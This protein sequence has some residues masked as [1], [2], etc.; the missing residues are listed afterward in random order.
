MKKLLLTTLLFA[1]PINAADKIISSTGNLILKS[2]ASGTVQV[3]GELRADK[4][5]VTSGS[6]PGSVPIGGMVAVMPTMQATDTWQP[7]AT[8]AIKDGFMRADGHTIT[9]QNVTDGSLLR[10][11]T[12]LPNMVQKYPRGNTTSG[13]T[14]G[15]NT[16]ASSVTFASQSINTTGGSASFNKNVMNSD[17]NAPIVGWSGYDPN[18]VDGGGDP[19]PGNIVTPNITSGINIG[20]KILPSGTGYSQTD[21]LQT[22]YSVFGS[23]VYTEGTTITSAYALVSPLQTWNSSTVSTS[24]S[25]PSFNQSSLTPTNTAVNNEPA[26]TEVVWVIRVK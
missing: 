15:A 8:G 9:A 4:V 18:R 6:A 14:G 2:G 12:V 11:G 24:F 16:Q 3:Q 7:P 26:Y 21:P 20:S 22:T 1:T 13:T 19:N 10:V 5:T 23:G 25:N 17:A